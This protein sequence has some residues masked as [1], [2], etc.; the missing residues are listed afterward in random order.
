[1]SCRVPADLDRL[2]VRRLPGE[3]RVDLRQGLSGVLPHAE[4]PEGEGLQP[5]AD[6]GVAAEETRHRVLGQLLLL[7]ENIL[8]LLL[9]LTTE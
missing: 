8:V 5:A 7:S 6:T 9:R 1:M 3:L 2:R 4:V